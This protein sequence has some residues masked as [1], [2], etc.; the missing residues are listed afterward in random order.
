MWHKLTFKTAWPPTFD[1]PKVGK[2]EAP[3]PCRPL[4]AYFIFG[5]Y[6]FCLL[7]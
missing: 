4:R 1:S 3:Y 7:L 5:A 6:I 2:T